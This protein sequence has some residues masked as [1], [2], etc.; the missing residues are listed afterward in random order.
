M[1]RRSPF[2]CCWF[3]VFCQHLV[4]TT[5]LAFGAHVPTLFPPRL[6]DEGCGDTLRAWFGG[7]GFDHAECALRISAATA[8]SP[9]N[10][11]DF[12]IFGPTACTRKVLTNHLAL[13]NALLCW[14][15]SFK[16]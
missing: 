15:S 2:V 8:G 1:R 12:G 10:I 7:C 3:S 11:I 5:M 13:E 4:P 16:Y 9:T 14:L 6:V